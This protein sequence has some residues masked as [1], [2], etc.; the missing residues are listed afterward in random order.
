ML[1]KAGADSA[2]NEV[3]ARA[4][5]REMNLAR[6]NPAQ[7]STFIE[8][9]R[10]HFRGNILVLPGRTMLRTKEGVQRTR[11]GHTLS[12][13]RT[14]SAGFGA[15]SGNVSGGGG[16]LRRAGRRRNGAW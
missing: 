14:T 9:V 5:I 6:T 2:G 1:R 8:E 16:S 3:P 7:Y 4:V 10:R 12:E 11:R 15:F 13:S